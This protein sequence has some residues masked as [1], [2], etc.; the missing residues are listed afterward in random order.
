MGTISVPY[1]PKASMFPKFVDPRMMIAKKTDMLANLFGG[2][3]PAMGPPFGYFYGNPTG[4]YGPDDLGPYGYPFAS[5][6]SA[7]TEEKSSSGSPDPSSSKDLN[8]EMIKYLESI[9]VSQKDTTSN[10]RRGLFGSSD[11]KASFSGSFGPKSGPFYASGE[12]SDATKELL[13]SVDSTTASTG[14]QVSVGTDEPLPLYPKS[15]DAVENKP[16]SSSLEKIFSIAEEPKTSKYISKRMI[17]GGAAP[18][19]YLPGMYGPMGPMYGPPGFGPPGAFMSKKS[20]FLDTLFKNLATSTVSPTVTDVPIPKSTI[21]PPGFWLP[22]TAFPEPGA[23]NAKVSD[24]LDKLF[25]SLKLNVSKSSVDDDET[26]SGEFARSV[27]SYYAGFGAPSSSDELAVKSVR[28]LDD[29]MAVI[30][31]KDQIV[32]SIIKELKMLKDDMVSTFNDFVIYQKNASTPTP[33]SKPFKPFVPPFWGAPSTS[34]ELGTLPYKQRMVIL[35]QVFDMLSE[36]HTN[37]SSAISDAVKLSYAEEEEVVTTPMPTIGTLN[38]SVLDEIQKKL[39]QLNSIEITKLT[40]KKSMAKFS[41]ALPAAP[42][43][44]WVAYPGGD[45]AKRNALG[46]DK[47]SRHYQQDSDENAEEEIEDPFSI[48]KDMRAIKMQMHQGYQS[49]PPGT[50]ESIQAGGG[51]DSGHEGG[52]VKLLVS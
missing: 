5:S 41:R 15:S 39:T 24:F 49:L 16:Q 35:D 4:M 47:A 18:T 48:G 6:P 23:Y 11:P 32:D 37:I 42:T 8:P 7:E 40:P 13:E 12:F 36:L 20:M 19:Q 1:I 30:V 50:V 43:S 34:I 44:F 52:G 17:P 29:P 3:G 26:T 10:L 31:T 46:E 45:P 33:G 51:S 9:G 25:D 14:S 27:P 38:I 2:I 21:V 22:D 28:S